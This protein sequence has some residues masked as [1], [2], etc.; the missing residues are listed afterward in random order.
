MTFQHAV[1]AAEMAI[2]KAAVADNGLR[3][4]LTVL[5]RAL[6]LLWRTTP[7]WHGEVQG[8][9]VLYRVICEGAAALREVSSSVDQQQIRGRKICADCEECAEG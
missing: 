1:L 7:K 8:G 5:E 6:D 9:L 4:V 3:L 2:A